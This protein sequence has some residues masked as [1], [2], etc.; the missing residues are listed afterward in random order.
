MLVIK[1]CNIHE[2]SNDYVCSIYMKGNERKE[3]VIFHLLLK[4]CVCSHFYEKNAIPSFCNG[5]SKSSTKY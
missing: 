4:L 5:I 3:L 1:Y 2:S